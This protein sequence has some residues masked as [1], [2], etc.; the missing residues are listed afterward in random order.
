ME[1]ASEETTFITAVPT[2]ILPKQKFTLLNS[3]LIH[4][5]AWDEFLCDI[6]KKSVLKIKT[7]PSIKVICTSLQNM[8]INIKVKI[9]LS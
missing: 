2:W 9:H 1:Q 6:I 4:P 3:V 8:R 5:T 7:F